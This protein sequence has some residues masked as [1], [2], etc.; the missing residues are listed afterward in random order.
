MLLICRV[1]QPNYSEK[2]RIQEATW[3]SL[4]PHLSGLKLLTYL[5][6]EMWSLLSDKIEFQ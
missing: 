3:V 1:C 2:L 5:Q 6:N 4:T